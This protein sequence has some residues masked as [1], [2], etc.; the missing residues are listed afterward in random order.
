MLS[1]RTMSYLPQSQVHYG[2]R[3][4][5]VCSNLACLMADVWVEMGNES[6]GKEIFFLLLMEQ[7]NS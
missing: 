7:Q 1:G 5:A 6:Q 3:G 2:C 4:N